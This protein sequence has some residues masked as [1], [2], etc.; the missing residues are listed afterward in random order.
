[1]LPIICLTYGGLASVSRY[2][3]T[4]MVEVLAQDFIRTAR[5]KGLPER[6]V[7][8]KHGLRNALIPIATL[9]GTLLPTLFAGSVVVERIFEIPGMG[10]LG[11]EAVLNGDTDVIM[12][13]TLTAAVSVMAGLLLTDLMYAWIDPRIALGGKGNR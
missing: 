9:A 3:R 8:F 2:Q 1:V 7:L 11:F 13:V 10:R 4:A 6:L 12:A 5:A